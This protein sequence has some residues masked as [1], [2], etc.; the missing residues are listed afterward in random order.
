[1]RVDRKGLLVSLVILWQF[2]V[3]AGAEL[4]GISGFYYQ[5]DLNH[6]LPGALIAL[7]RADDN[8][9][10][11][12]TYTRT[13]GRFVL[14]GPAAKGKYYVVATKDQF[15]HKLDFDY[16][17]QT[18]LTNL[19]IQHHQPQSL[20]SK[21]GDFVSN[22]FSGVISLLMGLSIG[23]VFKWLED[24]KKAQ[25]VINREI[26]AIKDLRDDILLGYQKLEKTAKAYGKSAGADAARNREEYLVTATE[27]GTQVGELQKQLDAKTEFEEAIYEV[28][29]LRGRDDYAKLRKALREIKTLA[30][31][32]VANRATILD[33]SDRDAQM[34]KFEE[35]QTNNLFK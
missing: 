31:A 4:A 15:S 29:K 21:V 1:M 5:D 8:L 2:S 25:K 32:V 23:L 17:P 6:P 34:K 18:P 10:V 22:Q 3:C 9:L 11:D 27:I 28:N 14:K 35:L 33:A 12:Y 16:D 7:Y 20:L 26:K 24:R 30:A 13:D 19:M